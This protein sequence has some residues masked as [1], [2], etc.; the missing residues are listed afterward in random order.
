MWK[1]LSRLTKTARL[2][3]PSHLDINDVTLLVDAHVC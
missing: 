3:H 2:N 1:I